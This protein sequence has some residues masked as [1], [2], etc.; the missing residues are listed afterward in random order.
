MQN[1]QVGEELILKVIVKTPASM[2]FVTS[3]F[4]FKD[5]TK[6]DSSAS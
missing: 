1:Y 2:K 4:T 6:Y 3:S 5:V